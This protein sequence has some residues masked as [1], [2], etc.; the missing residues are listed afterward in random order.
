MVCIRAALRHP[1][2]PFYGIHGTSGTD[3]K[4]RQQGFR[5]LAGHAHSFSRCFGMPLVTFLTVAANAFDAA[6][7]SMP[8]AL[9]LR[10]VV[11][12]L[13]LMQDATLVV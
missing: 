8:S 13:T 3:G 11:E 10:S 2:P 5:L 1:A 6:L 9:R 12:P 7:S 4:D